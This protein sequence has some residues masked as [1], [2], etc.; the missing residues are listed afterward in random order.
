MNPT[1][2]IELFGGLRGRSETGAE[3]APGVSRAG[4]L[5]ACLALAPARSLTREFLAALLWP[6]SDEAT[7]RTRL[8]QELSVLR[9]QLEPD[10]IAEG[11][12][13]VRGRDRIALVP[14]AVVTDVERFRAAFAAAR[15]SQE[16]RERE[17]LLDGA[18]T[19]YRG[20]LLPGYDYDG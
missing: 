20:E 11:S 16:A 15:K 6:E 1:W 8:R 10:G 3:F 19:L 14:G 7:A 5:L 9:R 18:A 12:V 2:Q 13:L 4:T 17:R